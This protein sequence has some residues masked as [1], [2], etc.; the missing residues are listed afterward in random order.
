[1]RGDEPL[2]VAF[3]HCMAWQQS[4]HGTVVVVKHR[5][6]QARHSGTRSTYPTVTTS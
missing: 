3:W 2:C 5:K 6:Y 1:M 4:G